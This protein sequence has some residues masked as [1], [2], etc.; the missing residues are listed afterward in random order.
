MRQSVFTPAHWL[1]EQWV[2]Y[3]DETFARYR[4]ECTEDVTQMIASIKEVVDRVEEKMTIQ[5]QE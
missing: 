3:L 5:G 2:E 4:K 1:M